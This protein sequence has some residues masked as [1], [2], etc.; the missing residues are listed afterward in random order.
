VFVTMLRIVA[1]TE[2]HPSGLYGV[3]YPLWQYYR[4]ALPRLFAPTALG[5]ASRGVFGLIGMGLLHLLLS[6]LGGFAAAA[7]TS[8]FQAGRSRGA[9][10]GS[11]RRRRRK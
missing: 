2:M 3:Q 1:V 11:G 6:A 5:S 4:V 10:E 9:A 7:V 8:Q